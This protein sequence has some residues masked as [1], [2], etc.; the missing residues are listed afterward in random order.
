MANNSW[1]SVFNAVYNPDAS[2]TLTVLSVSSVELAPVVLSFVAIVELT[3]VVLF[4]V[5][6]EKLLEKT[7]PL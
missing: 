2:C 4:S 6:S 7:R 1:L 3:P 5:A